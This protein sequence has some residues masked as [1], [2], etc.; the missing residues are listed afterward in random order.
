MIETPVKSQVERVRKLYDS[1]EIGNSVRFSVGDVNI[2]YLQPQVL[3][4]GELV[5]K[6][7]NYSDCYFF[8]KIGGTEFKVNAEKV[9]KSD[10][11]NVI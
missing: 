2:P 8:V 11:E 5:K 3:L 4:E 10:F 7:F 9:K 1:Y 6:M